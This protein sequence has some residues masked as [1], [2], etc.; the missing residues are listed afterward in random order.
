MISGPH[1]HTWLRGTGDECSHFIVSTR[2]HDCETGWNG[3]RKAA[4]M[5]ARSPSH[6]LLPPQSPVRAEGG[7]EAHDPAQGRRHAGAS[8]RVRAYRE[9]RHSGGHRHCGAATRTTH[10]AVRSE[11]LQTQQRVPNTYRDANM[12]SRV[13]ASSHAL[14]LLT[15]LQRFMRVNMTRD[16]F[17]Q[18]RVR[19]TRARTLPSCL[20]RPGQAR[21]SRPWQ[22]SRRPRL[23]ACGRRGTTLLRRGFEGLACCMV[24]GRRSQGFQRPEGVPNNSHI[25]HTPQAGRTSASRL[26]A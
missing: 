4:N 5:Q 14:T 2:R 19:C 22:T 20:K 23:T 25:I 3:R 13:H 17:W 12:V 18:A 21:T 1:N 10:D 15:P 16:A 24:G 26:R 8:A 6:S 9:G 11:G 7:P